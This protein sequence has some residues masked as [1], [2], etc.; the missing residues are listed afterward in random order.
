MLLIVLVS[1]ASVGYAAPMSSSKSKPMEMMAESAGE[2]AKRG[3][4][5]KYDAYSSYDPYSA[6]T[7]YRLYPPGAMDEGE[8]AKRDIPAENMNMSPNMVPEMPNPMDHKRAAMMTTNPMSMMQEATS[9]GEAQ[10]KAKRME[11]VDTELRKREDYSWYSRYND[12]STYGIYDANVEKQAREEHANPRDD[13]GNMN[14]MNTNMNENMNMNAQHTDAEMPAEKRQEY[15]SYDPYAAY[16][17]YPQPDIANAKRSASTPMTPKQRLE[18]MEAMMRE[19]RMDVMTA[20]DE[21][22]DADTSSVMMMSNVETRDVSSSSMAERI[23][24]MEAMVQ[25]MKMEI[26]MGMGMQGRRDVMTKA[27]MAMVE[28]LESMKD[29]G[30]G[31]GM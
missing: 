1:F 2:Q 6:Y 16:G 11:P 10:T 17:R 14:M 4:A 23:R 24:A 8:N 25:G 30:M 9:S 28:K 26:G 3:Q 31:N 13:D 7:D 19:I 12:Y 21:G 18:Q 15:S 27:D 20:A 29:G 22:D 5:E